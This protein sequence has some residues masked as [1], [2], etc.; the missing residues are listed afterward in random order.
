MIE[1]Q[2]ENSSVMPMSMVMVQ[3]NG[4][5]GSP[6]PFMNESVRDKV[7]GLNLEEVKEDS[8]AG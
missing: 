7:L 8:K 4:S 5:V 3:N 1:E 2:S 6:M